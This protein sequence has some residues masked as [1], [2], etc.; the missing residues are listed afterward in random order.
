M[1]RSAW[2]CCASAAALTFPVSGPA[3]AS[4]A[5]AEAT[6][7]AVIVTARK[8]VEDVQEIPAVVNALSAEKIQDLGGAADTRALV[9][10]LPGVTFIDGAS[11]TVSEPN[12]RGAGQARLPN[13]DSAIG[14][15]R[16]GAY[17]AGGNLGGR[18]FQRFDLFDL[19]RAEVL[20][21]PQG[22]LYGR[23]AVGGAINAITQ[24]PLFEDTGNVTAS[25]GSRETFGTQG[26][27][28]VGVSETFAVRLGADRTRQSGCIYRRSDNGQCYDF[29]KYGALRAGA[30][31]KPD[32]R[33]DV[34]FV[35]DYSDS[36]GDSGGAT[37]IRTGR[38]PIDVVGINGRNFFSST[39][40][41]FNLSAAY[42]LGWATLHSTT[43]R[44]NRRSALY[45]DP[46][47]LTTATQ[48]DLRTDVAT[49]KYQEL[50]LQGESERLNWL[51]G[52]DVFYLKDD[53]NIRERGRALIVNMA[54]MT[55]IDPN[56]DLNT[57]LDQRSY[58]AYGAVGFDLTDRITVDAEARYSNDRKEGEIRAVL[59]TGA[60]RY[61]DFP[62]GSPQTRPD[63]KFTNVSWGLTGSF[64]VTN[65]VMVYARA[66]TAYRAGGFNSELGNPCNLPGEVPGQT[67][68]LIDVP[69]NYEPEE[70][71][72][73][74]AGVKSAWFDRRLTVNAN[75]YE[76]EYEDLLANLN[77]GIMPMVDPLNGAMF[78]ANA[79]D[80]TARGFEIE[81]EARP[82]LPEGWGQL[83]VNA[84]AGHQDGEF[85]AP[86]AFL[87]TVREGSSLARL[88]PR[89][90]TSN[91]IWRRPISDSWRIVLSATYRQ[92]SGGFQGAENDV[93]LDSYN[94]FN[95]R[96]ALESERLVFELRAQNLFNERYFTN[97][98]GAALGGGISDNYRL[99]DPRY[100][101]AAVTYRW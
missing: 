33:L 7:E 20:R 72:T 19:E 76:I 56:S 35:A 3:H 46:D 28:N 93:L 95:G 43:N 44:R 64:K 5:D 36:R 97:Q 80:A 63:R 48:Q 66:A 68:N 92:E 26:V 90:I 40:S 74:E 94:I 17:I 22:A 98:S 61:S 39:Q 38:P 49:T 53:Y 32:D 99:N 59:V 71:I 9:Q 4:Q 91:V 79:G 52:A 41:N 70:S 100:V 77:N 83:T 55:T 30:R 96:A 1:S 86:P 50:R 101:E 89:S 75:I 27:V 85:K 15:Y 54:T 60:P 21:G 78:L 25:Y 69:F 67:C 84:T 45:S 2:L 42:D 47:G 10:L 18:A 87:T 13:S 58:A 6:V 62:P 73:Y 8:R 23:N 34:S 88:R 29:L 57:V 82:V 24:K 12:I 81:M 51:I 11:S 14:L 65:D 16:D 37:L 31:W